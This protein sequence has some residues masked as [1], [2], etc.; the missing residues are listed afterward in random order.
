MYMFL[1]KAPETSSPVFGMLQTMVFF[2]NNFSISSETMS[3]SFTDRG[4]EMLPYC[5]GIFLRP[6]CK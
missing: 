2:D 4:C 6:N 5:N 1:V 3:N